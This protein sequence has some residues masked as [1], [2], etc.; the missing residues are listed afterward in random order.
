MDY[1]KILKVAENNLQNEFPEIFENIKNCII[2]GSTGGE[3]IS[4]VGKYL[5]DLQFINV[6]AYNLIK[7]DIV[8]YLLVC[9]QNGIIIN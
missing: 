6:D 8:N 4:R 2:S 5:K 9:K 7:E 3:I 1:Q